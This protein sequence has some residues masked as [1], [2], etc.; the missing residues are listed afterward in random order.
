M[1]K[2]LTPSQIDELLYAVTFRE[3]VYDKDDYIARSD[4]EVRDLMIVVKGSVRGEMT[5]FNG[6][7][8]KIEDIESPRMLAPAFIFGSNNRFPG[9]IVANERATI[10]LISKMQFVQLLHSNNIVLINYLNSISDKAQFLS[11]KLKFFSFQTIKGKIAHYLLQ[12]RQKTGSDSFL[13]NKPQTEL[14]EMFGV[15]RPSLTRAMRELH[16]EEIIFAD[17]KN[18]KILDKNK[19]TALLRN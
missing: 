8:I 13:L 1:F 3:K 15:A 4:D 19:L 6:K 16:D 9:D 7:T 17:G 5:D 14:A 10:I 18:I 11:K 2:G 12:V